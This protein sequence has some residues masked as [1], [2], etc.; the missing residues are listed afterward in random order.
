MDDYDDSVMLALLPVTND[1]CKLECPHM[2]LVYV[3]KKKD[4]KPSA[5]NELAKDAASIAMLCSQLTVKVQGVETFGDDEKVD[6][7]T[8]Q[9]TP[10][11][12]AMRRTVESWNASEYPFRPHATIGPQGSFIE[13]IPMY[14]A[15]NRI[16]V[17]WGEEKIIFWLKP[18]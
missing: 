16:M 10:E 3:G 8:L 6:V 1:W 18:F 11:L 2:T 17:G 4:L 14:L 5:F 12:W 9:P 7:L 15:F 13:N